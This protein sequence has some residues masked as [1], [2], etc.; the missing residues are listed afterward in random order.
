MNVANRLIV[1]VVCHALPMSR[2]IG[3]LARKKNDRWRRKMV[4]YDSE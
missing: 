2:K 4:D 1:S 3:S